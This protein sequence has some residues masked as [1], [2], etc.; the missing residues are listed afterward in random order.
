MRLRTVRFRLTDKEGGLHNIS[1]LTQ[2]TGRWNVATSGGP[3]VSFRTTFTPRPPNGTGSLLFSIVQRAHVW[4]VTESGTLNDGGSVTGDGKLHCFTNKSLAHSHSSPVHR[5]LFLSGV[6]SLVA[7]PATPWRNYGLSTYPSAAGWVVAS[8]RYR[9]IPVW[10]LT[11]SDTLPNPIRAEVT[12]FIFTLTIT[13]A[14]PRLLAVTLKS[15][16]NGGYDALRTETLRSWGLTK[17]PTLPQACLRT[18]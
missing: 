2:A 9:G 1:D 15:H 5:G 12:H 3:A 16:T 18:D 11:R 8:G 10:R 17:S 7:D 13:K 4:A 14:R 6:G